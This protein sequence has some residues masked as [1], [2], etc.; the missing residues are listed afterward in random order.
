MKLY[1]LKE[2]TAD[3]MEKR[4]KDL[5]KELFQLRFKML[6]HQV[7]KPLE[8]RSIKLDIRRMETIIRERRKNELNP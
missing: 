6:L 7:E 8:M 2:F 5:K 4:I 1:K 3:E